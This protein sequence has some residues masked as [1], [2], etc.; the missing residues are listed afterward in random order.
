MPSVP[1]SLQSHGR[2]SRVYVPILLRIFE[3]KYRDGDVVLDFTL[4]DIRKA[5]AELKISSRNVADV[6]YRMRA[7]TVL[8]K[9][10]LDKGFYILRATGRGKYRFEVAENT[11]FALPACEIQEALDL[12]PLPVRRLLPK[13]VAEIDEQGLLTMISYCQLLDHFTGLKVYRLRSH[14]RK[15]VADIGQ[16]EL[17]E[18]DVGVALR[19]DERPIIFPIEAKAVDEPVNRVQIAAMVI[20][21]DQY[22]PGHEIRPL[23]IKLDYDSLIHFLEFN[24]ARV[25]ADLKI[26]KSATYR[27]K[28]SPQQ[29]ALFASHQVESEALKRTFKDES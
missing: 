27:L 3:E 16:A 23:A 21:C 29:E 20:F 7:R 18:I 14:V 17:D 2:R 22:F 15:S 8:P 9:A 28:M 13:N 25:S 10:I 24:P 5:A 4:D 12:T 26:V 19:E 1:R 11:I 6:V